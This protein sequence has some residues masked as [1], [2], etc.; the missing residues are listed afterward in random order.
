MRR[1]AL[2]TVVAVLSLASAAQAGVPRT[3]FTITPAAPSVTSPITATWKV[4]R[5]LKPGEKFGFALT[6]T[7]PQATGAPVAGVDC[8]TESRVKAR[9]V[10]K[11]QV[12]RMTFRPGGGMP[13][14]TPRPKAW[15][16]GTAGV[17]LFRYLAPIGPGFEPPERFLGKHTVPIVA[18]PG[19]VINTTSVRTPVKVTLLP[20]SS[21]T[22]TAPGRADRSTPVT[23]V[24]RGATRGTIVLN[25]DIA[26]DGFLGAVHLPSFA[27][28]PLCPGTAPP[29]T[30]EAI[31]GSQLDIGANGSVRF[32]L[33]LAGSPAQ[34]F[35]CGPAGALAGATTFP[36]TGTVGPKGL[37]EQALTGTAPGIVLPGGTQGGLVAN[38]TV[39]IDLSGTD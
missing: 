11:G 33:S 20:G 28:D 8:A 30:T 6:V 36:L 10:R 26:I 17:I 16:T 25:G 23:G 5:A 22:A 14:L 37:T 29:A 35:G 24:V 2:T 9:V 15:C 31:G 18:T 19:E 21:I 34:V 1:V 7:R 4:D 27:P 39:N 32:D 13:W 38:L 3:P 12:L